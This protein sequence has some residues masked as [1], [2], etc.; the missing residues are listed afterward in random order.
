MT[1]RKMTIGNYL[2]SAGELPTRISVAK[3]AKKL[4]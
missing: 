2:L 1:M 4:G 3:M